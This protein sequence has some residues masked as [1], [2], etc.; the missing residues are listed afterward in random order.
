LKSHT[1]NVPRKISATPLRSALGALLLVGL[2]N[3]AH[4]QYY[5]GISLSR[6]SER[7]GFGFNGIEKPSEMIALT[8]L[9]GTLAADQQQS[10]GIKL[11]YRFNPYFS[12]EGSFADR[13]T[14]INLF[15]GESGTSVNGLNPREKVMT[16][17]LVGSL[18][19]RD[20]ITLQSR[21][22][23]KTDYTSARPFGESNFV[24]ALNSQR[25]QNM[26][27]IGAGVQVNVSKSLGLRLDVERTRNLFTDRI[28]GN[29][30][31]S[32]RDSVNL[33][34]LWRF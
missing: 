12:L 29:R 8:Q 14:Q 22:G 11:G 31:D 34:V 21:A 27:F 2:T 32:N 33:G 20:R 17:D 5:G 7:T 19:I 16:I 24:S 10:L 15:R 25:A 28:D 23:F 1:H 18:P 3:A 6:A 4:A 9:T 30:F 26:A 13:S